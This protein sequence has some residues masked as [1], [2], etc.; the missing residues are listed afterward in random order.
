[1]I[2][3]ARLYCYRHVTWIDVPVKEA[4][5]TRRR[6]VQA[7][8]D[9]H[10]DRGS[11][12]APTLNC[13]VGDP[14]ANSYVCLDEAEEI[15]ANIPGGD[16]WIALTEEEKV[17]SLIAATSL[18]ETLQYRG[19]ICSASQRLKWP[20]QG[21]DCEGRPF[22]CSTIPY[23][24]KEATV[25]LAMQMAKDPG[26]IIG[27]GGVDNSPA[28]TFTKRQKL[29]DLEIEYAQFNNN[30]GS[31]CDDC[32]EPLAYQKFPWLEAVLGCLTDMPVIG[33][34]RIIG[35]VRS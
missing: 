3:V 10:A 20:R 25:M 9:H 23:K 15:A 28:G 7:G 33:G 18:L 22:D 29:G 6:L 1:M 26:G 17:F 31:N 21:E 4:K 34:A 11:L 8:C 13:T 30:V 14:A 27:G 35:R 24:V 12:M 2:N 19:E 32:N 5:E 16:E